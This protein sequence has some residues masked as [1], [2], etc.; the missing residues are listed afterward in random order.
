MFPTCCPSELVT[1]DGSAVPP[2][3]AL[4]S[5]GDRETP[6]VA[7]IS[8]TSRSVNP[9][10]T[11]LLTRA[12]DDILWICLYRVLIT[13]IANGKACKQEKMQTPVNA[14]NVHFEFHHTIPRKLLKYRFPRKLP[15]QNG[16]NTYRTID[17]ANGS[18]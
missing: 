13:D 12:L 17:S 16:I 15:H 10:I 11:G 1:N 9:V 7:R 8:S 4:P 6:G 5:V 2:N 3:V 14:L 18:F